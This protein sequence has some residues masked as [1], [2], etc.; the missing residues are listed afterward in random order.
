M[1]I[2]LFMCS[3]KRNC[4][5]SVPISTFTCVREW[6]IHIFQDRSTYFPAAEEA[7]RCWE[8]INRSQT[9]EYG[10][11]DWGRA[12]PFLGIFVSNFRY[13]GFAV[14]GRRCLLHKE[15]KDKER[16]KEGSWVLTHWLLSLSMVKWHQPRCEKRS[17]VGVFF[18][19]VLSI[20]YRMAQQV[21]FCRS[22]CHFCSVFASL[23]S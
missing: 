23:V 16:N 14:I 8:Y 3:Q 5:A 22:L 20:F 2:I 13:S 7:E 17:F 4:A 21:D 19:F 18:L 11:W 6:F 9:H 15:N 10:N 1:K 12:I